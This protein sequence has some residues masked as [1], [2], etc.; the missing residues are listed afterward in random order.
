MGDAEKHEHE[1]EPV[2]WGDH[3][4]DWKLRKEQ[5]RFALF[6]TQVPAHNCFRDG[7]E[8]ST[9]DVEGLVRLLGKE[10]GSI[11]GEALA[12]PDLRDL[13]LC[14]FN[15]QWDYFSG[16][17]LG[18]AMARFFPDADLALLVHKH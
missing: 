16:W 18:D 6:A 12:L 17:A 1:H 2:C 15:A 7:Q 11:W 14:A 10:P 5:I 8:P 4:F 3:E 9:W 13:L